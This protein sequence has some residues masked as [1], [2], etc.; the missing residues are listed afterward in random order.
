MAGFVVICYW[1]SLIVQHQRH[2]QHQQLFVFRLFRRFDDT[3]LGRCAQFHHH[4]IGVGAV[5][6]LDEEAGVES[7]LQVFPIILTGH[8]FVTFKAEVHILCGQLQLTSADG[9][10]NLVG[11]LVTKTLT[12]R[13]AFWKSLR[14]TTIL[15]GLSTGMTTL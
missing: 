2:H 1:I 7:D 5:Q 9:Q 10:G 14:F 11:A 12:R 8:A 3:G 4:F 15:Y 6:H 13:R